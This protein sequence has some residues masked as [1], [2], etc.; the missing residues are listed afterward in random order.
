M[1]RR[2]LLVGCVAVV[3]AVAVQ[4]ASADPTNAKNSTVLT[5]VCGGKQMQVVTNGNGEFTPGHVVGST[6]TI[7][8]TS[9]N[10]TF[11][12]TPTGGTTT[13]ETD[14]SAKHN[15]PEGAITCSIPL[16]LNT[17]PTP[18]GTFSISGTVTGFT[19]PR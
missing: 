3:A 14:M 7:V 18:D 11:S 16:A 10:L 19:T 17:F 1:V 4:V 15:Q 6:S 12:F 13:S 2:G 5:I 9:F 8:P